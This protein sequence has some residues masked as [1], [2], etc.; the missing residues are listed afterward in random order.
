MDTTMYLAQISHDESHL[1]FESLP[2]ISGLLAGMVHVVLGPDHLAAV[3]PM[4]IEQ[5]KRMW[6]AGCLWGLGHS[7]SIWIV[8]IVALLVRESFPF[9]ALSSWAEFLVGFMLIAIG[10]WG[11][12]RVMRLHVHSHGHTHSQSNDHAHTH[13][14][15]HIHTQ[16]IQED[17]DSVS[18]IHKHRLLGIGALHGLAGSATLLAILPA[19]AMPS[20]SAAAGYVIAF[21]LGSILGMGLFTLGIG[22]VI[23]STRLR[24]VWLTKGFL[25]LTSVASIGIG[26]FWILEFSTN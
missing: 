19:L 10:I 11:L 26:L 18:H 3:A 23:N 2:V 9:E 16:P 17:H 20:R 5:R 7:S 12:R 15:T 13:E 24:S 22:H 6:L 4:A 21:G 1:F 8:A 25:S 14:H